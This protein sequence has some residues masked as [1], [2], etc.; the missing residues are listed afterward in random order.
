MAEKGTAQAYLSE[1]KKLIGTIGG[2]KI[3]GWYNKN[4]CD[5]GSGKWFWC[6]ATIVYCAVHAGVP[7][8]VIKRTASSSEMLNFFKAQ[9]RY[10]SRESGYKPKPA[11]IIFF[12]YIPDDG[13]PASHIGTVVKCENGYVYT[14]EGNSGN[15]ADG[16]VAE[17]KYSLSNSKIRGYGLPK[18][19]VET[20][21][22]TLKEKG[23]IYQ[24]AYK[25]VIGKSSKVLITLKKGDKV[26]WIEDDKF[27]WSKVK[28]DGITG[29]I[30]NN[31]LDKK[32]LSKFKKYTLKSDIT[33]Q[34]IAD[35][36]LGKA[37][38]LKKGTKYTLICEIERG[39]CKNCKYIGIEKNRY[40]L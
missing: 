21:T 37:V 18:Y 5:I 13:R 35:K 12:D 39:M 26:T 14:I 2:D 23:A 19:K 20:K 30:M 36:K 9:D 28:Y 1:V 24:Y 40:Y 25:D 34:P 8:D 4:I 29:W 15:R 31:H 3:R 7:K 11:D 22:T 32:D 6:C 16:E 10:K 17:H 33:A 38:K 27:G